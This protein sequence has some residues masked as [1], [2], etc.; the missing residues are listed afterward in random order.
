MLG[1][2]Q[3]R[4]TKRAWRT[5]TMGN[6]EFGF[7]RGLLVVGAILVVGLTASNAIHLNPNW[8]DGLITTTVLFSSLTLA[9][10]PAWHRLALWKDMLAALAV[11]LLALSV[12]VHAVTAN[13]MRMGGPIRTITVIVEGLFLLSI[14]WRRNVSRGQGSNC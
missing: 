2:R 7:W 4:V 8:Q 3:L 6:S 10:R 11:H 13:A 12:I 5:K 14:L 9:L 1:M